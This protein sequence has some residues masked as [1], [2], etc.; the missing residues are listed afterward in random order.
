MSVQANASPGLAPAQKYETVSHYLITLITTAIAM[1]TLL[2]TMAWR[3]IP[4]VVRNASERVPIGLYR[5]QPAAKL[6]VAS[7]AVAMPR[8]LRPFLADGGYLPGG[9]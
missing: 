8:R 2:L 9:V 1:T 5:V 6:V 4:H 3:P 7:L